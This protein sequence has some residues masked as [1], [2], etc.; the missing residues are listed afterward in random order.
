VREMLH[1]VLACERHRLMV[2]AAGFEPTTP[3][4][5]DSQRRHAS[6]PRPQGEHHKALKKRV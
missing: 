2:G 4:P 5:P 6:R 1:I 3:S